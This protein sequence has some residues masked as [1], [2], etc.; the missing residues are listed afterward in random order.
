MI[1]ILISLNPEDMRWLET[2]AQES[3]KNVTALVREAVVR[4]RLSETQR[5]SPAELLEQTAGIWRR[6]GGLAYQSKLHNEW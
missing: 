6:G 4:Y 2:K 3:G 5:R 1:R